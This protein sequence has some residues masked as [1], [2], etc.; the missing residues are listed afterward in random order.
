MEESLCRGKSD[1]EME[2]L[3]VFLHPTTPLGES[4]V[5]WHYWIKNIK[6]DDFVNT[7]YEVVK[8]FF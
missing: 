3:K 7:K 2:V 6:S 8:L 4:K 1:F 5:Y